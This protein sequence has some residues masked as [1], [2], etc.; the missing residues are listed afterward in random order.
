MDP[1]LCMVECD[2]GEYLFVSLGRVDDVLK[3]RSCLLAC[4]HDAELAWPGRRI[5]KL[6]VHVT[7][8]I[9]YLHIYSLSWLKLVNST[10]Y[11]GN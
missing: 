1:I 3:T 6:Y 10:V 7:C 9:V 4:L 5:L 8:L 11:L 2:S